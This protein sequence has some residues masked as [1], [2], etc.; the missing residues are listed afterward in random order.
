VSI[1]QDQRIRN[2]LEQRVIII[3]GCDRSQLPQI[4]V[5]QQ[6]QQPLHQSKPIAE[7]CKR[8]KGK[9]GEKTY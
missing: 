7:E 1:S 6:E 5:R 3:T 2:R 4:A 9:K 8:I